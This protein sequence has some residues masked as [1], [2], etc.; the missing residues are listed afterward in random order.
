MCVHS[1]DRGVGPTREKK[2]EERDVTGLALRKTG[3]RVLG[4]CQVRPG[5]RDIAF[6]HQHLGLAGVGQG[7]TGV[8]G[9]GSIIGLGCAGVEGQRQIEA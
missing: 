9:D 4:C 6:S 8:G 2:V 1:G 5:R 7:K 3:G